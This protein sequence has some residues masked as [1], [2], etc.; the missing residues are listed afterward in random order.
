MMRWPFPAGARVVPLRPALPLDAPACRG[1]SCA[2]GELA[3]EDRRCR[4]ANPAP[5]P[6]PQSNTAARQAAAPTMVTA[7]SVLPR[8]VDTRAAQH[9]HAQHEHAPVS[10]MRR[11][12]RADFIDTVQLPPSTSQARLP[13]RRPALRP[14][15]GWLRR[16]LRRCTALSLWVVLLLGVALLMAHL[17]GSASEGLRSAYALAAWSAR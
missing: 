11:C 17:V 9:K 10:A 8:S 13:G 5:A 12:S 2:R 6:A 1:D 7:N 15:G 4:A 3:C 14:R 16:M